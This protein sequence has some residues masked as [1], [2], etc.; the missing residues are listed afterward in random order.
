[1][2]SKS[3]AAPQQVGEAP[4]FFLRIAQ[5]ARR[6]VPKVVPG[7]EPKTNL[8]RLSLRTEQTQIPSPIAK[9]RMPER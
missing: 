4:D 9:A 6:I 2:S 1:M 7:H 5:A 8:P 3:P